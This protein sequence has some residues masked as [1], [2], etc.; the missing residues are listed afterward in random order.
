MRCDD[1]SFTVRFFVD[2][3]RSEINNAF[4]PGAAHASSVKWLGFTSSAKTGS[5]D[6]AF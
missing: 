5:S 1:R 6:D 2:D 3:N 4:P